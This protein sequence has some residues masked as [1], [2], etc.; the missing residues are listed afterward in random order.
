MD[1]LVAHYSETAGSDIDNEDGL[2]LASKV[3]KQHFDAGRTF[4]IGG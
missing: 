1:N 3:L 2:T 4:G